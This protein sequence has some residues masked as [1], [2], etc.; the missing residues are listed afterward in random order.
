MIALDTNALIR[1]IVYDDEAQARAVERIL[2]RA[3]RD[4]TPV[5]LSDIVL[6]EFVW[7]LTSRLRKT[8]AEIGEVL[9][10]ILRTELFVFA[11][12]AALEVATAAYAGGRGDFADY[13]IRGQARAAGAAEVIT[14][15]R[16]LKG[17]A[18]YRVLG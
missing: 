4:E 15:D 13:V 14:F 2:V 1:L 11:D 17:E 10:R 5:F 3:R 7:V 18:G 16:A 9:D 6:C 8:R 12:A